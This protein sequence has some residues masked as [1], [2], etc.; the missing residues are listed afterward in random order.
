MEGGGVVP[1]VLWS[2]VSSSTVW[3]R[4][5]EKCRVISRSLGCG[6]GVRL[7]A[8]GGMGVAVGKGLGGRNR[9]WGFWVSE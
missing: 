3:S 4:T 6:V 2:S 8:G 9:G 5:L 7:G 1:A